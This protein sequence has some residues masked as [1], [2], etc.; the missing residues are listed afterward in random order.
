[1]IQNTGLTIG[2]NVYSETWTRVE[3]QVAQSVNFLDFETIILFR[4]QQ[5]EC[6]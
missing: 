2:K 3:E 5:K 1:M 4:P 6:T